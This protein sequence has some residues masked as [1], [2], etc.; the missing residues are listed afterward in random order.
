MSALLRLWRRSQEGERHVLLIQGEPGIGKSRLVTEVASLLQKQGAAVLTGHFHEDVLI[1]YQPFVELLQRY[2]PICPAEVLDSQ[3]AALAGSILRLV[4]ELKDR[5]PDWPEPA[6]DDAE[7]ERFRLFEAVSSL[8]TAGSRVQPMAI[9][10]ED[11]HWADAPS[12]QLLSHLVRYREDAPM[13]VLVTYREM[14][15][16]S[17]QAPSATLA[18]LR[19]DP[20]FESLSLSGLEPEPTR[21]LIQALAGRV[22]TDTMARAIHEQTEGNPFFVGEVVRNLKDTSALN[23]EAGERDLSV[24]R[25]VSDVIARRLGRLTEPAIATLR[26]ASVLGRE[27]DFTYLVEASDYESEVVLDAV[28]QGLRAQL[29]TE[30]GS[31][32]ARYR[33]SHALVRQTLYDGMSTPRRQLLHQRVARVLE[34]RWANAV[35]RAGELALHFTRSPDREDLAKAVRYGERAARQAMSVAAHREAARLANQALDIQLSLEPENLESAYELTMLLGEAL[36]ADGNDERIKEEVAP[37]A[38]RLA[39]ALKDD[40]RAFEACCLVLDAARNVPQHDWLATIERLAENIPEA[41]SR[42]NTPKSAIALHRGRFAE[43][44]DLLFEAVALAR[45]AGQAELA[46]H[47]ASF[48]LRIGVLTEEE[49]HQVF[50]ETLALPRVGATTVSLVTLYFDS[51]NT[52]LQWGD[53]RAAEESR[54]AL[55]VLARRTRHRQ[56]VLMSTGVEAL[57]AKLDGR[58]QDAMQ[59]CTTAV[60]GELGTFPHAW[61]ARVA[62]WIGARATIEEELAWIDNLSLAAY[63]PVYRAFFLAYLGRLDEARQALTPTVERIKHAGPDELTPYSMYN[64]MLEPVVGSG[65]EEAAELLLERMTGDSRKLAKPG[66]VLVPRYLGRAATLLGRHEE[67]LQHYHEAIEFGDQVGYRTELALTRL[68]L[69]RL[70]LEHKPDQRVEALEYLSMATSEFEAMGMQPALEAALQLAGGQ[71]QARA[72]SSFGLSQRQEEV[73]RLIASGKTT[74][75]IA[76]ALV[77]SERTVERHIADVYAKIGARNRAEATAFALAKDIL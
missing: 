43:A 46:F 51:V 61:R 52:H 45:E 19:R 39:E 22:P 62:A 59:H 26:L 14:D 8:L 40:R 9:V 44:R 60:R 28:E 16:S 41:R 29:L 10:L 58:L 72:R 7:F 53:R 47:N 24:P 74:R 21:E 49:E 33:F 5:L 23:T 37:R 38:L 64:L 65:Y 3:P 75:E 12:L 34:A 67:A 69:A 70:M 57:F 76:E 55:S 6:K 35:E 68:D 56:A 42:L 17:D 11:L 18:D 36:V 13:L 1:P 77:L 73:L 71:Q 63:G 32:D 20:R 48:L 4:P 25:G 50:E 31:V 2:L 15:L 27:F 66:F 54:Q 30:L